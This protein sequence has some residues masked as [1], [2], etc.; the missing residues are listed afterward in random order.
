MNTSPFECIDT[1]CLLSHTKALYERAKALYDERITNEI[2]DDRQVEVI[3]KTLLFDI[4]REWLMEPSKILAVCNEYPLAFLAR[5]PEGHAGVLFVDAIRNIK[6]W[7]EYEL[8][9]WW[10]EGIEEGKEDA[11]PLL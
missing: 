6:D 5:K 2:R 9:A 4:E 8:W 3:I 1:R 7:L 10:Y 11:G